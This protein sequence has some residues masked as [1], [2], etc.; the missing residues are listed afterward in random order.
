VHVALLWV[1]QQ[2]CDLI[3]PLPTPTAAAAAVVARQMLGE[4]EW[5]Q[6]LPLQLLL[7]PEQ[8]VTPKHISKEL[9][10]HR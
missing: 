5:G 2:P 9:L 4:L 7:V 3:T 8:Q 1:C 6:A 10:A